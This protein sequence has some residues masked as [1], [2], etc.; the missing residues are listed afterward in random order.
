MAAL[1]QNKQKTKEI[2][3]KCHFVHNFLLAL[4][5]GY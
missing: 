5:T 3:D 4:A 1:A 2:L